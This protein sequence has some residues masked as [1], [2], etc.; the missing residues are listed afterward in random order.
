MVSL[1]F[2]STV[3]TSMGSLYESKLGF[4]INVYNDTNHYEK[5][6]IRE[7]LLFCMFGRFIFLYMISKAKI[8]N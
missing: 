4:Q 3:D 7:M 2:P 8:D 5:W 1:V 6:D